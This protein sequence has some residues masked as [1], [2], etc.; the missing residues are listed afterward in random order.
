MKICFLQLGYSAKA[1]SDTVSDVPL[2][3]QQTF[4]QIPL[5]L[6]CG[7]KTPL[8][9]NSV[10]VLILQS[11]LSFLGPNDTFCFNNVGQ[12]RTTKIFFTGVKITYKLQRKSLFKTK[13]GGCASIKIRNT[14]CVRFFIQELFL[15]FVSSLNP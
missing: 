5:R 8:F 11:Y 10:A 7:Q 1:N 6:I 15:L 9:S 13:F 12:F 2:P 14:F 3:S 4:I